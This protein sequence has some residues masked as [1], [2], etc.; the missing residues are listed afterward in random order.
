MFLVVG[1]AAQPPPYQPALRQDGEIHIYLQPIPQEAHRLEF[2]IS[3][4]S[5]IRHDGEF[6]QLP[7]L[8]SQVNAKDLVGV[9]KRLASATSP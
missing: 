8:L 4:L 6:V 9:Q 3:A 5:A 7:L 1:C 2:S